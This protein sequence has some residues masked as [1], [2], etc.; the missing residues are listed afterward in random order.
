MLVL[1]LALTSF[2]LMGTGG[3]DLELSDSWLLPIH[4]AKDS[5]ILIDTQYCQDPY[6]T[7]EGW[8]VGGLG[9]N[10]AGDIVLKAGIPPWNPSLGQ[11]TFCGDDLLPFDEGIY[12]VEMDSF[13][14]LAG[15]N[16][17]RILFDVPQTDDDLAV[18]L[19]KG[20]PYF[21][22]LWDG[23]TY[24]GTAMPKYGTSFNWTIE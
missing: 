16:K 24:K 8:V 3:E 12:V 10:S 18:V 17:L 13:Q 6:L 11:F 7:G 9:T 19:Y 14:E 1:V 4:L 23:A 20:D 5:E 21:D 15:G 2:F 22:V